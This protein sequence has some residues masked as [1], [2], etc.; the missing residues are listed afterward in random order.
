MME[1]EDEWTRM[2][3]DNKRMR[4]GSFPVF[5]VPRGPLQPGLRVSVSIFSSSQLHKQIFPGIGSRMISK[6]HK[7]QC[8]TDSQ[9]TGL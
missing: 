5:G 7:R 2:E 8:V 9:V 1:I 6:V 4:A 3:N